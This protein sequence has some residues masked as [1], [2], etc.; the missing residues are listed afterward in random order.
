MFGN[1]L[2]IELQSHTFTKA[3]IDVGKHEQIKIAMMC[4]LSECSII[5]F[6]I[7]QPESQNNESTVILNQASNEFRITRKN[8]G[9]IVILNFQQH[10]IQNSASLEILNLDAPLKNSLRSTVHRCG[11]ARLDFFRRTVAL[12]PVTPNLRPIKICATA[13]SA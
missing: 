7:G 10:Q 1:M 11:V 9:P 5:E 13:S 4:R 12:A 2:R 3:W 8:G 6:R